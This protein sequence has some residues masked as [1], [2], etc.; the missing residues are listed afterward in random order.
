MSWQLPPALSWKFVLH[1]ELDKAMWYN[2]RTE[3]LQT[4][5]PGELP[6]YLMDELMD[7]A[8]TFWFN[9][10]T[11]E[12]KWENPEV[13]SWKEVESEKGT[14]WFNEVTGRT[15]WEEPVDLAW[16]EAFSETKGEKYYWN[17][18]TGEATFGKP[19]PLAWAMK[20]EL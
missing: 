1:K 11:G 17:E 15:Q 2:F 5:V 13:V 7:N 8:N 12:M 20:Q 6:Q 19:E 3:R 4:E 18:F 9:E 16:K 10:A 14:F